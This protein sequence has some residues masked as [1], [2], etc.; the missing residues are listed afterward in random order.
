MDKIKDVILTPIKIIDNSSGS[1]LHGMKHTEDTYFGFG[2]AYFSFVNHGSIKGWKQHTR[3]VLNIVV[4]QGD[5]LFV[6]F[7]GRED[8]QTYG[9]IV[10]VALSQKNYQRLTVPPGIWM[11][12]KGLGNNQNML[13]NIASIAHDPSEANT[14]PLDNELINYTFSQS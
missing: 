10:E 1:V 6:L 2:E 7:D 5:I 3:M 14:L 11:A 8:S 13:L 4:P 9:S 12:F